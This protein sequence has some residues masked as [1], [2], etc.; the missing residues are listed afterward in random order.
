MYD[1]KTNIQRPRDDTIPFDTPDNYEIPSFLGLECGTLSISG[2]RTLSGKS[3]DTGMRTHLSERCQSLMRREGLDDCEVHEDKMVRVGFTKHDG[4]QD[5][6]EF[7]V[8]A[9]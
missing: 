8:T 9:R 5:T 4:A 6:H 2:H 3:H 7:E 1:E